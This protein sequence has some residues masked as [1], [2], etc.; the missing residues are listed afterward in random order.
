MDPMATKAPET[1]PPMA[2]P[3][4][5]ALRCSLPRTA[6]GDGHRCAGQAVVQ[7]ICQQRT[8][9]EFVMKAFAS[10]A[11]FAAEVALYTDRCSPLGAFLPQAKAIVDNEDGEFRD[12]HGHRMPPCIVMEKGESLDMWC[13]RAEPDRPLVYA[14]RRPQS[15]AQHAQHAQHGGRAL[16]G[17]HAA[18]AAVM[19]GGAARG[20][21]GLCRC[22]RA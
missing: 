11:T 15:A 10:Q 19:R 12:A 16:C 5:G 18:E 20:A 21:C 3:P 22:V 2:V 8:H 17:Q 7:L 9:R 6:S 13:R 4:L 14:V 1:P